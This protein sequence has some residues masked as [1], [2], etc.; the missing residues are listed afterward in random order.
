MPVRVNL[1]PIRKLEQFL[2]YIGGRYVVFVEGIT[3]P[4]RMKLDL[5]TAT[6]RPFF[7]VTPAMRTAILAE[8][9]RNL[10]TVLSKRGNALNFD[11]ASRVLGATV[12][13]VI[14]RRFDT[15]GGDVTLR[16]LSPR[17]V[18]HKRRA[19]LDPRIGIARGVLYRNLQR[20]RFVLR[21][22]SS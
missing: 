6:G 5:L 21:K 1:E 18:D 8:W 14:M 20:A 7:E 22:V 9:K 15:Q 12:K 11:A 19:G 10:G 2:R 17:Y 4:S 13:G 16:P 3:E